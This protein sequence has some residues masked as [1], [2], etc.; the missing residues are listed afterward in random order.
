MVSSTGGS[1]VS[2]SPVSWPT[3]SGTSGTLWLTSVRDESSIEVV[4]SRE[5]VSI[6]DVL[7]SLE[8]LSSKEVIVSV[9]VFTTLF[10]S[11]HAKRAP[12]IRKI[13]RIRKHLLGNRIIENRLLDT[14]MKIFHNIGVLGP[15]LWNNFWLWDQE[16]TRK[17]LQNRALALL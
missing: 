15:R 2:G 10:S 11:E 16:K 13:I 1:V 17:F 6:R 4:S 14:T 8:L 7:S 12:T 9:P 3:S 5:D